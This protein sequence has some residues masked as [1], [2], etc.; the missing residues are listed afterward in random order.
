MNT[1]KSLLLAPLLLLAAS[2]VATSAEV[3]DNAGLFDRATVKEAEAKLEKTERATRIPVRI[4]TIES[5]RGEPIDAVS[6]RLARRWAQPGVF[7]LIDKKEHK[8]EVNDFKSF[9]GKSGRAEIKGAF[10][11]GF[12]KGDFNAGLL[13]GSD[14][15]GDVL[16]TATPPTS[17]PHR[18]AARPQFGGQ[19]PQV[20]G[21]QPRRAGFPW[22]AGA[23]LIIAVLWI[24]LRVLG[25][26]FGGNR[27]G[28]P[29]SQAGGGY[30]GGG[31]GYGAPG[32]GYG[33]RGGGGFMSSLF[34]GI[35]GAMAGNWLYDQFSGRHHGGGGMYPDQTS[36]DQGV[37]PADDPATG[38][39]GGAGESADWGGG[40]AG[41]GGDWG[42]GG[43]GG[44]W[45][46]G[47]GGGGGD[48]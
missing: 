25:S 38:A 27:M 12:R 28:G 46:G 45:G 18:G 47:D 33:G 15:I 29:M 13:H 48:W 16:A 8:L 31:P 40:D 7:V 14:M 35:G 3:V 26:L 2:A 24:G 23:L 21:G 6:I 10:V 20:P 44:D 9:L 39:W 17:A 42:G 1:K 32:P 41:G 4:E 19:A 34:G 22:W 11:D 36:Y 5:L 30:P 37:N 43:G